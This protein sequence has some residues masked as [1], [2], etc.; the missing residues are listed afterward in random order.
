M[1]SIVSLRLS[2]F[3]VLR[4]D[5]TTSVLPAAATSRS[6]VLPPIEPS[7]I[8]LLLSTMHAPTQPS[9]SSSFGS[10]SFAFAIA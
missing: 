7:V 3:I 4:L 6:T 1:S 10:D 8:P 9:I 2:A 5:R